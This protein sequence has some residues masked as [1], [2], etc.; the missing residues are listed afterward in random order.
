MK[1][2][3]LL[4]L[5]LSLSIAT[6]GFTRER[7]RIAEVESSAKLIDDSQPIRK[8]DSLF[9]LQYQQG[10]Q[11]QMRVKKGVAAVNLT[12]GAVEGNMGNWVADALVEVSGGYF[13]KGA[14]MALVNN[15]GLRAPIA[16]GDITLGSLYSVFSFDNTI[17]MIEIE[18][19][20]LK[21]LFASFTPKK[22]HAIGGARVVIDSGQ[23][24]QILINKDP[25]DEHR[26]YRVI[27][28]DYLARGNDGCESFLKSHSTDVSP[29]TLRSV[30]IDYVESLTRQGKPIMATIDGRINIK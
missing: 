7:Y 10:L 23:I 25:I 27:T 6:E 24:E 13:S 22:A 28:V 14:D 3:Y 16:K 30:M 8:Q 19:Q 26:V 15:G 20:Y 1:Y 29:R 18:G 2:K 17:A 12:V 4:W 21:E 5:L 9:L 11:E